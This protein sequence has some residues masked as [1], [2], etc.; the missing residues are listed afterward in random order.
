[1]MKEKVS[2]KSSL[3]HQAGGLS[4]KETITDNP[5]NIS[6]RKDAL[7]SKKILEIHLPLHEGGEIGPEEKNLSVLIGEELLPGE[8]GVKEKKSSPLERFYP[9]D[10]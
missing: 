6:G 10:P 5:C 2:S 7:Q 9:L 4:C 8:G 1:M 3:H